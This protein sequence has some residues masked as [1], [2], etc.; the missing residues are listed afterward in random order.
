MDGNVQGKRIFQRIPHFPSPSIFASSIIF[1]SICSNPA[2]AERYIRGK[3]TTTADNTVATQ[4]KAIRKPKTSSTKLPIGRLAPK[5]HNRKKPATVGG[6]TS[7][8]VRIPSTA[9]FSFLPLIN[10]TAHAARIP[11]TKVI[12]DAHTVVL[13]E[14]QTGE[15]SI[16]CSSC[17]SALR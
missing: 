8:M 11:M 2:F 7:G 5:S 16:S 17:Y 14:I 12:T 10:M 6:S 15:K 3:E 13:S 9:A 4:E 1:W